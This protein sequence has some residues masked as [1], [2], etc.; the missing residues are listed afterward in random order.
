MLKNQCV[1][2]VSEHLLP[3]CPVYTKT[4]DRGGALEPMRN[5]TIFRQNDQFFLPHFR[6]LKWGRQ[7]GV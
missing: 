2:Y 7:E 6:S 4:T 1:T 3:M 5:M